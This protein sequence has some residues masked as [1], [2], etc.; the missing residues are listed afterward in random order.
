VDAQCW[1][2]PDVRS[3]VLLTAGRGLLSPRIRGRWL[4]A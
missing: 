4:P 2:W 1:L 3:A